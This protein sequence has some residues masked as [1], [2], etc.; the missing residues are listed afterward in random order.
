MSRVRKRR[1][2]QLERQLRLLKWMMRHASRWVD[3]RVVRSLYG[4]PMDRASRR[5]AERDIRQLQEAGVPLEWSMG[6]W[7]LPRMERVRWLRTQGR[8]T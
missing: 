2:S 7:R 6:Y 1:M 5:L 3:S 4:D 8:R